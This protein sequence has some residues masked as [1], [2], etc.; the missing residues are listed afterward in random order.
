MDCE[1]VARFKGLHN[2]NNIIRHS[3]SGTPHTFSKPSQRTNQPTNQQ[4]QQQK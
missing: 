4:Q 3:A 2:D 1:Q